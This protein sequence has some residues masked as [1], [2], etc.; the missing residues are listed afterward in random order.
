MKR[1]KM[2]I[3]SSEVKDDSF[4]N[5]YFDL[6]KVIFKNFD[7]SPKSFDATMDMCPD[8]VILDEYYSQKQDLYR[9]F[10]ERINNFE[11][12]VPVFHFSPANS[13]AH[14]KGE[15]SSGPIRRV[16]FSEDALEAINELVVSSIK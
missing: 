8:I 9:L 3:I 11:M 10:L 4:W 5:A 7:S 16:V 12:D 2:A 6:K 14:H 1:T 13:C 15:V